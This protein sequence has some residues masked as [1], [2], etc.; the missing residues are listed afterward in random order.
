MRW[1]V[2]KGFRPG[3][4]AGKAAPFVT[5]ALSRTSV[6]GSPST[7]V[8]ALLDSGAEVSLLPE[9]LPETIY[10][11]PAGTFVYSGTDSL[12]IETYAY[13]PTVR[14]EGWARE[15]RAIRFGT[16]PSD[17]AI[18]GRNLLEQFYVALDGPRRTLRIR[19]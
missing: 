16:W 7:T 2:T 19:G 10:L 18:L 8:D 11:P 1:K 15:F 17:Y 12:P 4:G 3:V 13:Y 14:L 6:K 5:V 9:G